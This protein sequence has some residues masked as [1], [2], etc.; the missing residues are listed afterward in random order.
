MKVSKKY[1]YLMLAFCL[2]AVNSFAGNDDRAGQAGATELLINPWARSSGWGGNSS[3]VRGIEAQFFNVAG[4]AFTK[5]TEIGFSH[6]LWLKGSDI[7]INAFGLSQKAGESGVLSLGIMSMSFGN[8]PITT[9]EQ[10]E[11]GLG[12]YSPQ[13]INIGLSY[14]KAFSNSI[15]GGINVRIISERITDV[16]AQGVAFDAGIQYVTGFNEA[17][18]NLKFGIALKNVGNPMQ[19]SG[20]GLSQKTTTAFGANIT[21][22][23][24]AQDFEIPS[25][26]NIGMAYDYKITDMHR[27]TIAAQFISNSFTK[28]QTTVGVEYGF[29]KLFM[30]RGGYTFEKDG[31]SKEL[32]TNVLSGIA[33]GITVEAP[34]GKSGKALDLDYSYRHTN[35]FDGTHSFGLVFKL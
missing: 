32:T 13:F 26:V 28:D 25:L 1:N 17:K 29:K 8:I 12:T 21:T 35:P 30:I 16:S 33:A 19:F 4:T 11:G 3:T 2:F 14:A 24:R 23:V 7:S 9:A 18:D 15:Y 27:L 34:L 5:K 10:P 31:T 20:D 22:S 6:T